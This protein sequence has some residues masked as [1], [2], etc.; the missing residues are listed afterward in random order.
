MIHVSREKWKSIPTDYKGTWQDYYHEKPEW[1]WKK[2]VMSGCITENPNEIVDYIGAEVYLTTET[3]KLR[4]IMDVNWDMHDI[5]LSSDIVKEFTDDYEEYWKTEGNT[6]A[7]DFFDFC[8][9]GQDNNNGQVYMY[10]DLDVEKPKVKMCFTEN[11]FNEESNVLNADGYL[12][13]DLLHG[14][15]GTWQ[16]YMAG[17]HYYGKETIEYTKENV[18]YISEHSGMLE[19]EELLGILRNVALQYQHRFEKQKGG[20]K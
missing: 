7:Q 17:S 14:E 13:S 15:P 19:K 5:T 1:I 3:S 6:Y 4:R 9:S 2:V 20:K 8:F 18:R 10:I 12:T 16:E 11:A